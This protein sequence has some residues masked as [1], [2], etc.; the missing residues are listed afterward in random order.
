MKSLSELRAQIDE[1][2]TVIL[3]AVATRL[4]LCREVAEWKR[5]LGLPV[6]QPERIAAVRKRYRS[7]GQQQGLR[8]AFAEELYELLLAEAHS[9]EDAVVAAGS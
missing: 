7:E 4:D 8:E 5:T 1:T 3:L 6:R 9:I 2:D